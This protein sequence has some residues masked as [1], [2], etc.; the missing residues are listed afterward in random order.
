MGFGKFFHTQKQ[1]EDPSRQEG[2]GV[3]VK[4][5]EGEFAG[6]PAGYFRKA[7]AKGLLTP[8][9][10]LFLRSRAGCRLFLLWL[11]L[12]FS[13]G[14]A[15]LLSHGEGNAVSFEIHGRTLTLTR[16]LTLTR[17]AV[18]HKPFASSLTCT[19]PSWWTPMSTKAPKA[20]TL[21]ITPLRFMRA[22]GRR[23]S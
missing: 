22:G 15:R 23:S 13:L 11:L 2:R 10:G 9:F 21:V 12:S 14:P 19:N 3:V 16:W 17:H 1:L 4:A 20:V 5:R 6:I 18:F 8:W 7:L